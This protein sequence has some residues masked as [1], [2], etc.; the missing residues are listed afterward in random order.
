MNTK[1]RRQSAVGRI[2]KATKEAPWNIGD[3]SKKIG[4]N[5]P[6]PEPT[7]LQLDYLIEHRAIHSKSS[8]IRDAVAEIATREI[9]KLRRVQEA[10]RRIEEE[11]RVRR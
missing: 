7:I 5:V 10:V 4:L 9:E 6:F 11:D 8:F 1:P 3:P 2:S